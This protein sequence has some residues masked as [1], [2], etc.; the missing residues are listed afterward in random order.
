MA[1]Q[2]AFAL[3]SSYMTAFY[4]KNICLES[5][6]RRRGEE[7]MGLE[8]LV[9]ARIR[10]YVGATTIELGDRFGLNPRSKSFNALL[11]KAMLGVGQ[12]NEIAEFSKAGITVRQFVLS[13]MDEFVSTFHFLRSNLPICLLR[14]NGKIPNSARCATRNSSLW[15]SR[16]M[17]WASMNCVAAN[18]GRCLRKWSMLLR[19]PGKRQGAWLKEASSLFKVCL[20]ARMVIQPSKMISQVPITT[21]LLTFVRT[22][23]SVHTVLR[24]GARLETLQGMRASCPMA[25]Q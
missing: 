7:S 4:D 24:M 5:I 10:E 14:R 25:A 6:M 19:R 12:E 13:N 18:S 23:L 11:T 17:N 2:R 20:T 21:A 22:P 9:K 1:K 8:D 15:C 16:R 3:K